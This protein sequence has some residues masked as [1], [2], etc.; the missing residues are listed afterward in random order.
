MESRVYLDYASATPLLPEAAAAMIEALQSYG[1][2]GAIH[3][4]GV[5]AKALLASA[6]ERIALELGC[7]AREVV[8]V[9]GGTEANN[10]SILGVARHRA[11]TQSDLKNTHW[12]VS[13]IEHPSV[14]E[15]FSEIERLGGSVTHIEP[16][17]RGIISP[18][19]VCAALKE[20]TVLVSVA[21]ANHE[22][23]TIQPIRAIAR[24]LKEKNARV[25]MHTDAGQ[26]PLYLYPHV[27]TLEVDLLSLDSGKLYG[28]R[29][30]GAVYVGR[31]V[32]ISPVML[33]GGQERGLRAGTE[34]VALAAGFAHAFSMVGKEREEEVKRLRALR[35]TL[36]DKLSDIPGTLINTRVE[37]SLPHMLN[38]SIPGASSEY[39]TLALDHQGFAISTKSACREGEESRSRVVESVFGDERRA[40]HTLRFSL[41]RGST[42]K[43]IDSVVDALRTIVANIEP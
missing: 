8:F 22:L 14:L 39:L 3:R 10:L 43:E 24:A 5:N 29:G 37:Q 17:E 32:A 19:A 12:I 27:H 18:E 25:L 26:A 28:P 38:V 40:A 1:N 13:A 36:V 42:Q 20:H 31:N 35:Q 30:I 4:E 9:S 16:D 34:N 2:P 33:G 41:G 6:R 21:W 15:C 11:C 7:K 23:G